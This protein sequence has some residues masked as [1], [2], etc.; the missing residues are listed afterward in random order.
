MAEQS[1]KRLRDRRHAHSNDQPNERDWFAE[2]FQ[3]N[4]A[5]LQGVAYR[6]LGSL[7]EADD[8]VQEAWLRSSRVDASDVENLTGWLTTII[9]RVALDMLRSR[10]ARAEDALCADVVAAAGVASL[11]TRNSDPELEAVMANS[12][13]LALM[14]VLTTLD[15]PERLAF[16]LHDM[17]AV[18][19]E[20]IATIVGRSPAATRQLA[21]RARRRVRGGSPP[22][23]RVNLITQ[24]RIVDTFV[25]ALRAGDMKTLLTVLDPNL[26]VHADLVDASGK[27]RGRHNSHGAEKWAKQAIAFARS[28]TGAQIALVDG[29][30]GVILAPFGRL[31]RA[32]K[33]T[34][35]GRK[36]VAVDAVAAP[37]RVARL[38]VSVAE[39]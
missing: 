16:V 34:F 6:I 7:S 5:H 29:A 36:I 19:F 38:E 17:F 1:N 23:G 13:G 32:L 33:F 37:A 4:R 39:D 11:E 2:R 30:V 20:E 21:S 22:K 28:R 15:P 9:A 8:A 25:A 27:T 35:R 24:R 10:D 12:V 3:A 26:V 31:Q 18:P 14:V